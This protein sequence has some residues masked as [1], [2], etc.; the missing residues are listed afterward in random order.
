[1]ATMIPAPLHRQ[2]WLLLCLALAAGQTAT[3]QQPPQAARADPLDASAAVPLLRYESSFARYRGLADGDGKT[4][5]W[6]E[7][8][9]QVARIGGWRV[10]RREALSGPGSAKSP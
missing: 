3:A 2:R 7:A 10:Y 5:S 9:E 4:I 1:M 8:N 6:R